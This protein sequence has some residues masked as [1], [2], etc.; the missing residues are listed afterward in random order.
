MQRNFLCGYTERST[1]NNKPPLRVINL[2]G[3]FAICFQRICSR[4]GFD[5]RP[6]YMF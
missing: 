4:L 5:V 2:N 6:P 3:N 1:A